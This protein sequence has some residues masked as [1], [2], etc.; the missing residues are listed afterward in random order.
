MCTNRVPC[1]AP[2][3]TVIYRPC[4]RCLECLQLYQQDWASR[5]SE[6]FKAWD[7]D[8]II[9]FTLTY[10]DEMLP[11]KVTFRHPLRQ[12]L[13]QFNVRFSKLQKL[14]DYFSRLSLDSFFY[15]RSLKEDTIEFRQERK[16]LQDT[17]LDIPENERPSLLVPTVSYED[18]NT[19]IRYC[20]KYF[21]RHVRSVPFRNKRV[22][23]YLKDLEFKNIHGV[24]SCYPNCA[25]TPSFK[26]FITSEYGPQTLRPHYHGVMMGVTEEMFRDV[27]L[28]YWRD[29]YGSG[30]KRSVK[31]SVYDSEK[32]GALYIAK[33]CTKGSFEHPLCSRSLHDRNGRTYLFKDYVKCN[34]WFGLDL[35][36][37]LPTFH[38]ISKGIGIRYSFRADVQNYWHVQCDEFTLFITKD[39][40]VFGDKFISVPTD[41]KHHLELNG[42]THLVFDKFREDLSFS[43]VPD[44]FRLIKSTSTNLQKKYSSIL[45]LSY[46]YENP[47][48]K[49]D[50]YLIFVNSKYNNF[51]ERSFYYKDTLRS[52]VSILPRYYR[53]FLLSPLASASLAYYFKCMSDDEFNRERRFVRLG[54]QADGSNVALEQVEYSKEFKQRDS[55]KRLSSRFHKFYST[56]FKGDLE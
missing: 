15:T 48:I 39:L 47:N 54:R 10:S 40:P 33:Y 11:V 25:Y 42:S 17:Y 45:G 28:P 1:P 29:K 36:L 55:T 24:N 13:F 21:D 6:E 26:Y 9:F 19:W 14:T 53:R 2:D 35:P 37:C 23:P 38:L 12:R 34:D 52:Y 56:T 51:Y 46:L 20:R 22:S 16:C 30:S 50:D 3:G 41:L 18:V 32:G 49:I 31:F 7:S 4:G 44:T 27:F 43:P 8:K 5:L